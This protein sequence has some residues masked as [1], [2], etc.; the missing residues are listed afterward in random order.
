MRAESSLRLPDAHRPR[1]RRPGRRVVPGHERPRDWPPRPRSMARAGRL[2]AL[3]PRPG[4]GLTAT[5]SRAGPVSSADHDRDPRPQRR[6]KPVRSPPDLPSLGGR[7]RIRVG[8]IGA[9]GYAGGEMVRLLDLHPN[10][11]IV[12]SPGS[13]PGA[14]AGGHDAIPISPR[15]GYHVEPTLPEADAV[16][17]ALPHGLAAAQARDLVAGGATII[18]QG[19]DFRLR[20]P[21]D[22]PRWYG[23]EHPGAGPARPVGLRPA[24][25]PPRRSSRPSASPTSPSWARPAA[26]RPRPS[27][28]SRRS[29]G[30]GSSP[31]S[32]WTP[33]AASRAPVGSPRPDLTF[34]E[35]NESVKAYG[36]GGHRHVAEMEQELALL[37][38][39]ARRQ[40]GRR[41]HRL[42]ASPHPDDP[43]HPVGRATSGR[44]AR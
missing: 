35:V 39:S 14:G 33:R 10:V 31:T 2:P 25:A 43:G 16:F 29:P 26:I 23:F 38:P 11:R 5:A 41:R 13:R 3:G 4:V 6:S 12:G 1:H 20:D 18:D 22:Y 19:P 17:L 7:A 15:T 44:R 42:P 30:P 36:I 27:W 40:P 8:I 9:T 37:S 24:G 34:S 32:W 21:A 28:R